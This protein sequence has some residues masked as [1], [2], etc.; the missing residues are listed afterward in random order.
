MMAQ[1]QEY[2]STYV[3]H[4]SVEVD[5]QPLNNWEVNKGHCIILAEHEKQ[6]LGWP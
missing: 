6:C 4:H 1:E 5:A 2:Y 3:I